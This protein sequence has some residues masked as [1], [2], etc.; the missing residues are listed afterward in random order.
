MKH[1]IHTVTMLCAIGIGCLASF[2]VWSNPE[3]GDRQYVQQY[4]EQT[5]GSVYYE[6]ESER[7][8]AI[9]DCIDE[10][11]QYYSQDTEPKRETD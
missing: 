10:Q 9:K 4:C 6:N 2:S 1:A 8:K 3:E 7:A 11:S 5:Y